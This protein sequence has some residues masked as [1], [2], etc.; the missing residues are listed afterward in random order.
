MAHATPHHSPAKLRRN[1]ANDSPAPRPCP[2][3]N[4]SPP[5]RSSR[6]SATKTSPSATASSRPLVTLWVFLSQVLDPDHSCR[7]AVARFLAWRTVPRPAACS[8]DTGAYCKAR[9]RLPEAVLARLTRATGQKT[10]DEAPAPGAGTAAPSRSSMAPPCPCPT[11]R[12]TRKPSPSRAAEAGRRLP[13]SPAWWCC[14]PWPWARCWTPPWAATRANGPA[15][16]PC[17][18]AC[19]TTWRRAIYCWRIAISAPTGSWPWSAA[20]AGDAGLPPAPTSPGRLPPRPA[21]GREDHVVRLGQAG[22]AGVDGRGD[23]CRVAACWRCG[24]CGC[25]CR[26]RA[27]GRRCWWW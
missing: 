20:A 24:S 27:S 17:S 15:R 5:T 7:A 19:T 14:S 23:L 6:P 16:R 11:R 3:P 25:A 18:T 10:Q 9:G 4:C 12:P 2:S 21:L 8:T 26:W 13:R 22:A 1:S